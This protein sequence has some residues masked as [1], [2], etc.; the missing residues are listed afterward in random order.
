MTIL[1]VGEGNQFM[2]KPVEAEK[3]KGNLIAQMM[4]RN[5]DLS[6]MGRAALLCPQRENVFKTCV[7]Y[8]I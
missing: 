2:L 6:S 1:V 8:V 3:S 5:F 7:L 4:N